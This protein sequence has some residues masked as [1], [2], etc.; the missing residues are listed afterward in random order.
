MQNQDRIDL[1]RRKL[2]EINIDALWVSQPENLFYLSGCE[3]LE[4]YLF[5]SRQEAVMV[6][7]FR[8]LE[9]AGRQ[10]PGFEIFQ[11][12]GKMADWLPRLFQA[13]TVSSLGFESSHLTVNTYEQIKGILSSSGI[14]MSPQNGLIENLRAVKNRAEI[15]KIERAAGIT[16]KVFDYVERI[17][18][19]GLTE[20]EV[21]W[22][23]EKFMRDNGSQTVPFELIVAA[24]PNSALPHARPSSYVIKPHEPIVIDIGSKAEFYGS[25]LTRT[26]YLGQPDE[27]FRKVYNTVLDAQQ[28]AIAG[29]RA[30]MTGAEAD[31]L[32]R[33]VIEAAG[34]GEAFG[35]SLGH[36]IGLITH[37]KPTLGPNSNDILTEGMVF[38]VEPGIYL[39]GWGG[40][41]IEDDV[42]MENGKL[43]VIS[44][45]RKMRV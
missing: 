14:Q 41:R 30:G 13:R 23:I 21:A 20:L 3:G 11:I 27:T 29:I 8:Y 28:T 22:E 18:R 43:R 37:E 9:Q 24:G 16:D 31:S 6:T 12:K 5:I 42:V 39:S 19:P 36:G 32:A 33:K 45:G 38:T 7:D 10:S 15:E 17:L 4:G 2:A 35:H 1:L 34:Y 26:V 25:D 44:A 40:V